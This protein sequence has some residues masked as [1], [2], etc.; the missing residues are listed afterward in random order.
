VDLQTNAYLTDG[1]PRIVGQR[2]VATVVLVPST[3]SEEPRYDLLTELSLPPGQYELRISAHRGL[4]SVSGSIYADIEV[5]DFTNAPL[6]ASGLLLEMNPPDPVAPPG[7]FTALVGMTPTSNREFRHGDMAAVF[8]R[9]YQG[10]KASVQPVTVTARIVDDH[11][12]QVG[13]ARESLDP[14]QFR[15]G[16]PAADFRFPIPLSQL[17]PGQYLLAFDISTSSAKVTRSVQFTVL[18]SK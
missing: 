11:D 5:P 10:V 16:G 2:H 14:G 12:K 18:P 17:P 15:I 13:E 3:S 4:D 1:R 9:I 8:M 6:S 7:R